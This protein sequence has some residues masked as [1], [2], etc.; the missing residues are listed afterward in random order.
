MVNRRSR[1]SDS[2]SAN[3]GW[4]VL[5]LG[6]LALLMGLLLWPQQVPMEKPTALQQIIERGVLRVGTVN[7]PLTYYIGPDDLPHGFEYDLAKAFADD[8]GVSLRIVLAASF[9][10]LFDLLKQEQVD[11]LAASLTATVQREQ[12][13]A[14][15]PP[16]QHVTQEV[17]YR[18]GS[19]KPKTVADL[20]DRSITVVADS[21]YVERLA[22]LAEDQE[23]LVFNTEQTDVE[24][25]LSRVSAREIDFTVADSNVVEVHRRFYPLIERAFS[26]SE[27]QPLA[28][29]FIKPEQMNGDSSLLDAAWGFLTE[30]R[31]LGDLDALGQRYYDH[32]PEY[33]R[34]NTHYFLRHIRR[35]LPQF[36]PFFQQA[37]ATHDLDW[38]L[39][40]A[41]GYQES[42]WRQDAVSVTGVRGLMMLTQATADE[43]GVENRLDPEQSIRGGAQYLANIKR[44]LP[45]RI[46]DPDRTWM[47]LAAYNVGFGHLEDARVL[48]ERQGGNPDRWAD[49]VERLP[50]LSDP[51]Y[52]KT[53]RFGRARGREPVDYVR[54]IRSYFDILVWYQNRRQTQLAGR[55][56]VTA[57]A[58]EIGE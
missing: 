58:L 4:L 37:A 52:Y 18:V 36:Q 23:D 12:R 31:E 38:R 20:A 41:M 5:M 17:V 2:A 32:L 6:T 14:F 16:Y 47:A 27:P 7:S 3:R 45:Q 55:P 56:E 28:W 24:T 30:F 19:S 46:G 51:S 44:R 49:V 50:L 25:L 35:R 9:T 21:S 40:A 53:L 22:Q 10:E 48:T 15:G 43:L 34:V 8:L 11:L 13:W 26:V 29:A 54:N 1:T 57:E 42:H 39:L 33:D